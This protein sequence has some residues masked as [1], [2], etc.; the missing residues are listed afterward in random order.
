MIAFAYIGGI[1]TVTGAVLGGILVGGGLI[2]EFSSLHFEGIT[3]SYINVVGAVGLIATA[4]FTS[5]EGTA[6]SVAKSAKAMVTGMRDSSEEP[7]IVEEIHESIEE[8][9]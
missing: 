6:L 8:T 3:R 5:G 2:S 7:N 1:T 9:V 4:I